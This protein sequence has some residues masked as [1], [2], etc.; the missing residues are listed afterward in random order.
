MFQPCF[1]KVETMSINIRWIN[2]HFQSNFNVETML[3]YRRLTDIS[4]SM[5]FQR[6]FANVETMS[7]NAR[8]FNYHFQSNINVEAKRKNVDNQR[9]FKVDLTLTYLLGLVF[10]VFLSHKC[11]PINI[12]KFLRTLIETYANNCFYFYFL[13]NTNFILM[14]SVPL[15]KLKKTVEVFGKNLKIA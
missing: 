3:V 8:R 4:L 9:C 12:A 10:R 13:K 11:F 15:N 5:L 1:V 2:L 14:V 6:C 7:M